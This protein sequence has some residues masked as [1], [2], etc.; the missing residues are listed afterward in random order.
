M[1][2]RSWSKHHTFGLLSGLFSPVVFIPLI[3]F[4]SDL[5][6]NPLHWFLYVEKSKIISLACIPNLAWF[7]LSMKRKNYDFGMG[8][9]LAT[10]LYL[11]VII[12]YK[13]LI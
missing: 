5:L 8:V 13:F 2:L 6:G 9:I 11:L 10:I 7:H 12:Y 3:I 1:N 4:F